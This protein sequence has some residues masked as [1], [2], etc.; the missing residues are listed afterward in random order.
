M[1][2][3]WL[4]VWPHASMFWYASFLTIFCTVAGIP[5]AHNALQTTLICH[6]PCGDTARAWVTGFMGM[7][8]NNAGMAASGDLQDSLL[9]G[10][11]LDTGPA[12]QFAA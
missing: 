8:V 1:L 11:F 2:R 5:T 3:N 9:V 12:F 4:R 10:E 6:S 7:Q